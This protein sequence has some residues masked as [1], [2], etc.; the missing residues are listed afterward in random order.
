MAY[1]LQP[2]I[3]I[4]EGIFD[5][6]QSRW[7][8]HENNPQFQT[9]LDKSNSLQQLL[10]KSSLTKLDSQIREVAHRAEDIIESLMVHQMKSGY[11]ST[12]SAASNTRSW[13]SYG[14]SE[15]AHGDGG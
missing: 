4:L 11:D 6:H 10:D 1:N 3:T 9:I 14:A 2:L 13:F 7:I 12:R 5:P 15:E 8:V